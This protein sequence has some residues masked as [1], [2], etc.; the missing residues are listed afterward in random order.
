MLT[1]TALRNAKSTTKPYKISD[2]GGLYALIKP[3]G[4]KLLQWKYRHPRT[5][6]EQVYSLGV[7]PEVKLKDARDGRDDARALLR[8]GIDPNEAKH[9]A[10]QAQQQPAEAVERASSDV[11]TEYYRGHASKLSGDDEG[12]RR[13]HHQEADG[14]RNWLAPVRRDRD[15]RHPRGAARDRERRPPRDH[16]HRALAS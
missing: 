1:D 6:K 2:G 3:S 10:K 5:R 9:A 16:T 11:A 7:Y 13:A 12:P 4:S 8:Q 15:A 14:Q